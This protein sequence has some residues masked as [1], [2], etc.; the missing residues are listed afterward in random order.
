[1]KN[2]LLYLFASLFLLFFAGEARAQCESLIIIDQNIGVARSQSCAPVNT[3]LSA[4]YTFE[5]A[6]DPAKVQFRFFLNDDVTAPVTVA[7]NQDGANPNRFFASITHL[8]AQ[9]SDCDFL[10]EIYIVY[11]GV[12]CT[13]T[14]QS[15][16]FHVWNTDDK[17][18]TPFTLEPEVAEFCPSSVISSFQFRDATEFNC[19]INATN[20]NPNR[21]KR[22]VQFIYNTEQTNGNLIRNVEVNGTQLTDGSGNFLT[23]LSGPIEEVPFPA[24]APIHWT[25]PINAPAGSPV[26]TYFE[27]TMRNWNVCNPYDDPNIAGTPA[28]PVN[29]DN[30]PI[31]T[32]A[33]I[34]IVAPPVPE[35]ETRNA[36]DVPSIDFCPGENVRFIGSNSGQVAGAAYGYKWEI[37]NDAAGTVLL[38]ES[39]SPDFWL[40][41]GFPDAGSKLIKLKIQRKNTFADCWSEETLLVN[42]YDAPLADGQINGVATDALEF[43]FDPA[44]PSSNVAY[45]FDLFGENAYNYT[46]KLFKRNSSNATPDSTVLATQTV[47]ANTP[48]TASYD[49]V[50][51]QPG[52]YR[53]WLVA[54]DEVTGCETTKESTT[55]IYDQP[56]AAFAFTELCEGV[57]TSF[58]DASSLGMSVNGDSI[59]SWSW[60]VDN[61]G[62]VDY[63][64]QNP[65]HTYP[66]A[67]TYEVALEVSTEKGCSHRLLQEI[68]VYPVP[69]ASLGFDYTEPVCPGDPVVFENLS[70]ALN[71][72]ALFPDG[73]VYTL[74]I[75]DGL[76][77][78]ERGMTAETETIAFANNTAAEMVYT[79]RLKAKA[80]TSNCERL[81]DALE[82]RVKPGAAAG[83]YEPDYSLF[84]PNC[85]PV[86]LNFFVDQPT[87][88][89]GGDQHTWVIE[90][91]GVELLRQTFIPG[92]AG[93]EQ[94]TYL[95]E[96]N[97]AS[98]L[99]YDVH[100][101]VEKAGTC[102]SPVL[103]K[104][105]I[106]PVPAAE[107]FPV[108][109][110]Q[111]CEFT[112]MEVKVNN[113]D[114]I[115][116][117]HWN[118]YPQPENHASIV[119]DN[120]FTLIY[121]RPAKDDPAYQVD[122]SLVKENYFDCQSDM[123]E[124][125]F[126]VTPKLVE[127]IQLELVSA[128]T[129]ACSPLE[130][131]FR[132]L[133]DA[134]AGTTYE[135]YYI[136]EGVAYQTELTS[137][138]LEGEFSYTFT[139]PGSYIAYLKLTAPDGCELL[140]RDDNPINLV[141]YGD[142]LPYF[143]L[144]SQEGC[145]PFTASFI[146][147]IQHSVANEWTIT[148]L[149]TGN[150][151]GP[152]ADLSTYEFGNDTELVKTYEVLLQSLSSNGCRADSSLQVQVYPAASTA[153]TLLDADACAPYEVRVENTSVNPTGT[154]YTWNWDDGSTTTSDAAELSHSYSNGSFTNPIYKTITLTATTPNGCTSTSQ[155]Q[156]TLHPQVL[157]DFVTDKAEGCA[158]L[159]VYFTNRSQG[160]SSSESGWYIRESGAADFTALGGTLYSY[161]FENEGLEALTF[162]VLYVAKN[163]GGCSDSLSRNILVHPQM[164]PSVSQDVASGCGPLEV[165]FTNENPR[166]RE[167]YIWDWVDGS[168][169]DTSRYQQTT[170]THTFV[171]ES[172]SS[173]RTYRVQLQVVDTV[174]GCR[175]LLYKEVTVQPGV[176]ADVVP[177]VTEGCSP[178]QVYFQNYSQGATS[179]YW[180]VFDPAGNLVHQ[181]ANS[182]PTLPELTNAAD[183]SVVYQV[184]Y[185]A[186]NTTTGCSDEQLTEVSVHPG[187]E[188]LFEMDYNTVCANTEVVFTN[189]N[190]QPDIQYIWRWNDGE[191]NDTTTTETSIAHTF[192][193]TSTTRAKQ[194]EVE[195]IAYNPASDCSNS[196]KQVVFVN[197]TLELRV[198]P[199]TERGCAPLEVN[200][201]NQS[202]N[203]AT[204]RWYVREQ[205]S[206]E[207]E[208]EQTVAEA[209]FHLDNES[210]AVKNYE[211]VYVG[212]SPQ[213][214]TDSTVHAIAVYP[215]LQPAFTT[216]S[217]RVRL[218][219]S[220]FQLTNETPY[221]GSWAHHWDFGDGTTS[222]ALHPES[223]T[224]G[225]Y[226]SYT[227]TLTISNGMCSQS[228]SQKVTV[229][230]IL[231]I[232]DFESIPVAG[233]GPL[234]VQ[235]KNK[236]KYANPETYFWDFGDG[237]GYSTGV[238]P[239]YTY[240][241]P[242]EY[243]VTLT[244]SNP[245]G[246][247]VSTSYAIVT[248]YGRPKMDFEIR[249][250]VVYVPGDPVYV[251]NYTQGA[252]SYLWNFGDGTEY[253]E[254]EPVH[255]YQE[256][257]I[258][259]ITLIAHNEWGCADTLVREE[260]VTAKAG[261]KAKI[262]NAFTPSSGGP[263]GGDI[264]AG[265][266]DVFY[267]VLEGGI[268]RYNLKI[269]NRWGELLFESNN[270]QLGW[271]GYFKGRLSKA[272]V[273]V[274]KLSVEFSDGRT[275]EKLGDL[276]L[277]R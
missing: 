150:T 205:G 6:V 102:I 193:N 13:G 274:Y 27:V 204:H 104:Y 253:T 20:T 275:M 233:C 14:M 35:I 47:A 162:E 207:K 105:R 175:S 84:N 133:T 89:L 262:P 234:T 161:Q 260:V 122:I 248:V 258:Y 166:A 103:H 39:T 227:I 10:P 223:H 171:N 61:D 180:E 157:A 70:A 250:S 203:V 50:Y 210:G 113:M 132:N 152:Y 159:D 201:S 232:V 245:T 8:Y 268:V 200:F 42:V 58:T 23:E 214:C 208:Q 22:W 74:I 147:N 140:T 127:T 96:N 229:N 72:D 265:D 40:N 48:A 83:F 269:Y 224:Y 60:D 128:E 167:M 249:E 114:G 138:E 33:R 137:A 109:I 53:I 88:D 52:E 145:A 209:L 111:D 2:H 126:H 263:T 134:P 73:V 54:I 43:C 196:D 194:F 195:L 174:S 154:V 95:A 129:A 226:G 19:N 270:R 107:D 206:E 188:A 5:N 271:D 97:T 38:E 63:T 257:G 124:K 189:L 160:N 202:R 198:S 211:V 71:T 98:A 106:H 176:R 59:N 32:T 55:T 108:A 36:A 30:P 135:F 94:F 21:Q 168:E 151:D 69:Q 81:S 256:P 130:A 181:E 241:K 78:E 3:T 125:S 155:Q 67:G 217:V 238:N 261:G 264:G 86:E 82:V 267:P 244:A 184:R 118:I 16:A 112:Y 123:V 169:P 215:Q 117:L 79:I 139:N 101:L 243:T 116:D 191:P 4:D 276:T 9:G 99:V 222:N 231:P 153:F 12:L 7:A 64:T 242:G 252:V 91:D 221:A 110:T 11:D 182:F 18:P 185:R 163:T 186:L 246:E 254:F 219:N 179:H 156:L 235:F 266:N 247:V 93:Y 183:S 80:N 56:E 76:N 92:Q 31:E 164:Q 213:G 46:Y 141:V 149:A 142:P 148:D 90:A 65:T 77:T 165:T 121:K 41:G 239:T 85:S 228:Y 34:L 119:Y 68:T 190:I 57:A 66:T 136:Y 236:S 230:E 187:A 237:E 212:V 240:Y 28:D 62:A 220:T 146:K 251:A 24:D 144:D 192:V 51:S 272:D 29:G 45:T 199:D 100:L 49:A 197:P 131:T 216:D 1:M 158:P 120:E 17:N 273:Y 37:Y 44:N 255:Y 115:R 177:S 87:L 26:N 172:T 15:Q 259:T 143:T 225:T 25:L 277:V 218:P 178:L 173:L 170:L 75:S